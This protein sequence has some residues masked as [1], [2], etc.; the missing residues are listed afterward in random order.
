MTLRERR[1]LQLHKVTI[2]GPNGLN[3]ALSPAADGRGGVQGSTPLGWIRGNYRFMARR[4][5]TLLAQD[6]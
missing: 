3:L 4:I 1:L 6:S 5:D 2:T